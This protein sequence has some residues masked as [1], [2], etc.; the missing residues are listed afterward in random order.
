MSGLVARVGRRS[1]VVEVEDMV[2]EVEYMEECTG[3]P[4]MDLINNGVD[5]FLICLVWSSLIALELY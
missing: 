3:M 1:A 2:E 4:Y 5:G